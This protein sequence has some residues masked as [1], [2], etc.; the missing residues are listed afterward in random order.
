MRPT[1]LLLLLLAPA[2]AGCVYDAPP[3]PSLLEAQDGVLEDATHLDVAFGEG[4]DPTTLHLKVVTLTTD[5]E[6]NLADEDADPATELTP[7]FALDGA[8]QGVSTTGG[9]HLFSA[10]G[11]AVRLLPDLRFPVGPKLALLVEPGL[12]DLE[13]NTTGARIRIPF[14]YT[15]SCEGGS[16]SKVFKSGVYFF[17]LQVEEPIGTQV[18][19]LANFTVDEATGQF[20]A[21]AT[22]ADRDKTQVCPMSCDPKTEVCRLLP[23]PA[24]VAPSTPAATVE[25]YPDYV[26]NVQPP[27]GYSFVIQ[28]CAADQSDTEA[29]MLTIPAEMVVESPPV[30]VKGLVMTASFQLDAEG[31]VRGDGSLTAEDV[32]L[33][34]SSSGAGSGTITGRRVPDDEV[35]PGVPLPPAQ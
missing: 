14:S 5:A 17:L 18:Q 25:E 28:G 7:L 23:E 19:L 6:G 29:G 20:F 8:A 13:G 9:E 11:A 34:D 31:V 3:K 26:P 35:P 10:D 21:T 1:T 33:L 27:T 16:G 15:F 4:I 32:L 22:N 24:C 12:S 2:A 30:T